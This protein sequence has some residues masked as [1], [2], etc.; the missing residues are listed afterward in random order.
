[1]QNIVLA[2]WGNSE[3]K[4]DASYRTCLWKYWHKYFWFVATKTF[5]QIKFNVYLEPSVITILLMIQ[6]YKTKWT[7]ATNNVVFLKS[8]VNGIRWKEVTEDINGC[9]WT[10]IKVKLPFNMT[11]YEFLPL[12][13]HEKTFKKDIY[14]SYLCKHC[15]SVSLIQAK[16]RHN[17]QLQ[18]Q[19]HT[20]TH[21]HTHTHAHIHT[22]WQHLAFLLK[23]PAVYS[24][25]IQ[26]L[27][28]I[29]SYYKI[30]KLHTYRSGDIHMNNHWPKYK[31]FTKCFDLGPRSRSGCIT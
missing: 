13:V 24:A 28:L 10:D 21:T 17:R 25:Y 16:A 22:L 23:L 6:E 19:S 2:L 18:H 14:S 12:N 30:S 29:R 7:L 27:G 31:Y 11:M 9:L 26:S 1:M 8:W 5:S 15:S 4:K 3:K 20:C